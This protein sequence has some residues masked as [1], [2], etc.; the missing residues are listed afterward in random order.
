MTTS[1]REHVHRRAV[2]GI[3]DRYDGQIYI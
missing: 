2:I 1:R 3:A